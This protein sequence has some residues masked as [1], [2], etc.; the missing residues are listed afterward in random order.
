MDPSPLQGIS[1]LAKD[2]GIGDDRVR[3]EWGI[4]LMFDSYPG[5]RAIME[6]GGVLKGQPDERPRGGNASGSSTKRMGCAPSE[7]SKLPCRFAAQG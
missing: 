7:R 3:V 6:R 2:D 5:K 4:L 1:S